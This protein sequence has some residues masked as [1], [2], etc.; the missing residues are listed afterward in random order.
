M[1]D[2]RTT[3]SERRLF[4]NRT[5]NLRAIEAI[6]FDMDYTLVHYDVKAWERLAFDH[7]REVLRARGW[8]IDDRPFD[9]REFTLGLVMDLDLGNVAKANRFGYVVRA[10]H[11]GRMLGFEEQRATYGR[12][13]IDL[14]RSRWV[15]MNTLFSLSEAA[16]FARAVDL[17]DGGMLQPGL[18]YRDLYGA[19]RASIDEAHMEGAVK[20]AIVADP[21]RFVKADPELPLALLDLAHAGKKLLLVTNS[22]WSYTN[23][24]LAHAI[25][26]HLPE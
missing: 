26:P 3:P 1:T 4:C 10:S 7:A 17:L 2:T 18:S 16:L 13:M 21:A 15:F 5:L 9:P 12:E 19:I 8:P 24:I 20:A 23:A 25:D 22:A 11:G 6:G 14:E